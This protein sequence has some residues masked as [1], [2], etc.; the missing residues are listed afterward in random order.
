MTNIQINQDF[1]QTLVSAWTL[2][3]TCLT[4]FLIFKMRYLSN[5]GTSLDT[6][7][8]CFG[9]ISDLENAVLNI[10][11]AVSLTDDNHPSKSVYLLNLENSQNTRFKHLHEP[12]DQVA[13]I[14]SLKAVAQSNTAYPHYALLAAQQEADISYSN[15]DIACALEGYRTALKLLPKV[16]WLGLNTSSR[17]NW[18]LQEL[19]ENLGCLAATCAIQV[20]H[21]EEAVELL[22]LSHS[23]FW[24]QASLL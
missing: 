12:A 8:Q 20:G 22:D 6:H 15:G 17:Q 24:Q 19:P 9:H 13:S 7:F 14:S 16:A 23:V 18:L 21:L 1:I 3:L 5:L 11:R 10:Q 4:I 2:V